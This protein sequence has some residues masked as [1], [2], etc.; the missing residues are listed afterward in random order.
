MW[1]IDAVFS[2]NAQPTD[3]HRSTGPK[4]LAMCSLYLLVGGIKAALF[5]IDLDKINC[6]KGDMMKSADIEP[7]SHVFNTQRSH[8]FHALTTFF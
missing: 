5:K 8:G 6:F 7:D 2:S 1:S 4:K 3:F